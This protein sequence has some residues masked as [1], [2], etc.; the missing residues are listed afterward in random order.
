MERYEP[1]NLSAMISFIGLVG[2]RFIYVEAAE[3]VVRYHW[4]TH[5]CYPKHF[6]V[7]LHMLNARQGSDVA[8]SAY[9][10]LL[11]WK[12]ARVLEL[13]HALMLTV[14]RSV[15]FCDED[16]EHTFD[17]VPDWTQTC[18]NEAADN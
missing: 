15:L 14:C 9:D 2:E 1:V 10:N 6:T 8:S 5:V 16:Y 3:S 7:V 12:D 18:F 11:P 4:A 13:H 17:V